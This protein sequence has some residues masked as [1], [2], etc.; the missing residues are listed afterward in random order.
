MVVQHYVLNCLMVS[1]HGNQEQYQIIPNYSHDFASGPAVETKLNKL[2]LWLFLIIPLTIAIY[3]FRFQLFLWL[4]CSNRNRR[5]AGTA[6]APAPPLRARP[7]DTTA[8]PRRR[9][10]LIPL[11]RRRGLPERLKP[12]DHCCSAAAS[13]KHLATTALPLR[14]WLCH[15]RGA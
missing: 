14:W 4:G 10:P 5:K 2:F 6:T 1:K 9:Q 11:L 7:S 15:I 13:R 12:P 8:P 3:S